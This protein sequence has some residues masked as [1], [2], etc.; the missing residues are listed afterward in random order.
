MSNVS[1]KELRN[2]IA[3]RLSEHLEVET[4]DERPYI[5]TLATD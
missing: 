3:K 1:K 2:S 4:V 5:E